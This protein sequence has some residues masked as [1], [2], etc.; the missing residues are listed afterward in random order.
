M[1][2]CSLM[3]WIGMGAMAASGCLMACGSDKSEEPTDDT[4]TSTSSDTE[5]STTDDTE[6]PDE[7][8]ETGETGPT[9]DTATGGPTGPTAAT[10]DTAS[11]MYLDIVGSAVITTTYEGRETHS[12][13]TANGVNLCEWTYDTHDTKG[14]GEDVPCTDPDGNPCKFQFE[15]AFTNGAEGPTLGGTLCKRLGLG[16]TQPSLGYGFIDSYQVGGGEVATDQFMY[17]YDLSNAY[18]SFPEGSFTWLAIADASYNGV[19]FAYHLGT[20]V[21]PLPP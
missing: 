2:T 16:A 7:T 17:L 6:E 11:E 18:S 13:Q 1:K 3:Q 20:F 8:G 19:D 9:G 5:P 21:L 4:E 15:V 12:F 14:P 10:A